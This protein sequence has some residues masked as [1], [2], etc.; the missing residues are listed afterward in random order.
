MGIVRGAQATNAPGT[1]PGSTDPFA[2]VRI[3]MR[4]I[5]VFWWLVAAVVAIAPGVARAQC[6]DDV[7][8]R[9]IACRCGDVVV[10]DVHLLAADPVVGSRCPGDGLIVR[11]PQG[12]ASL[13]VDLG[14]LA[15][16]GSGHGS[17][18]RVLGT[19]GVVIEGGTV[20]RKG[21]ISGFATGVR[22]A[23]SRSVAAVRNLIVSDNVREG[24][25]IRAHGAVVSN[26]IAER[27]GGDGIRSTGRGSAVV[28][29]DAYA[30]GGTGI[31][32]TASGGRT[33]LTSL[34]NGKTDVRLLGRTRR[35]KR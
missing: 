34:A 7:G 26:V 15:I 8:G 17:G 22:A 5:N 31:V 25:L 3:S 13:I 9:R 29:V 28:N 23:G 33:G 30:N 24:I 2:L 19:A 14:G 10:S 32:S 16:S 4:R 27:N 6:G 21:R 20:D 11:P 1:L 35:V 18:I 12:S